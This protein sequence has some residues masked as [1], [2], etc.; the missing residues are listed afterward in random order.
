MTITPNI[1]YTSRDYDGLRASLL[2]YAQANFPSW[3]PGSE[4]DFGVLMVEL[5]AYLGDIQSYYTD[6]AQNEAYLPTA[7]QRSSVL[8]IAKLLGYKPGTG[9]PATG[10]V[11]LQAA[12]G[13]PAI[14]VPAGTQLATAYVDSLDGPI[15]FET[16]TT[17]VV[18]APA[19]DGTGG[20]WTVAVTEG[21]TV[22]DS[23]TGGP[24]HIATATGYPAQAYRLPNPNVYQETVEVFVNGVQWNQIDH[25]LEALST[26]QVF[27]VTLDA[28][29]Y[30][31]ISFGDG[32]NGVVPALGLDITA[33][34]RVGFGSGGN[35][36]AG[37]IIS[38]YSS[39]PG[40]SV[41]MLD[42]STASYPNPTTGG[43]DPESTDQ[44][45]ANAPVAF[46]TQQRAVNADDFASLALAVPGV[47]KA[48][49]VTQF[50]TN[51]TLY[52]IGPDGGAPS[53]ALLDRVSK[54]VQGKSLA[55]VTVNV[56]APTFVKINIG[57]SGTGLAVSAEI[58]PQFSRVTAQHNIEQAIK[59]YLSFTNQ[60]LGAKITV[61]ELY[62]VIMGVEGVRYVSIPLL[63][64]DDS[65]QTG[66]AD[67]QLKPLEFPVANNVVVTT[68]GG[69]EG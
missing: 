49:A 34:Y 42:A 60:D 23:T 20:T 63:A 41:Q 53:T 11:I 46:N 25:L 27:E 31:W 2:Q 18:P 4:G 68:T 48:S 64:R 56:E 3:Q 55:G 33:T 8:N 14:T 35:L 47:A 21:R 67:I 17:V 52:I 54:L 61:A 6:R 1:D 38:V 24:I 69:L 22:T 9:A 37:A 45:R 13:S 16:D 62:S 7:T 5:L 43:A 36:A 29:G 19:A 30:T 12:K 57:A 10:H 32:N 50:F 40:L 44:I 39:I 51:V 26:E 28:D 58:W 66:T 65:A 59:D 15:I